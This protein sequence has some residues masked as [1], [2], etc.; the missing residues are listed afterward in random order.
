ME[1]IGKVPESSGI[2]GSTG[3]FRKGEPTDLGLGGPR[4]T[5]RTADR[6]GGREEESL[7]FRFRFN[8]GLPYLVQVMFNKF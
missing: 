6:V 4:V 7:L 5:H 1:S 2:F 8:W 3:K